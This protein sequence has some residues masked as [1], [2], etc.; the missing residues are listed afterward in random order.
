MHDVPYV[1]AG[2]V[3]ARVVSSVREEVSFRHLA[4]LLVLHH[5]LYHCGVAAGSNED[6][7]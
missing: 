3:P 4:L 2:G 7:H 1:L 6:N 5:V